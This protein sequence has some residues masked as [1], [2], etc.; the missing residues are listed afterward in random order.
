MDEQ[1][2]IAG[3]KKYTLSTVWTEKDYIKHPTTRLNGK[4]RQ[5]EPDVNIT[6]VYLL[7]LA[8][9]RDKEKKRAEYCA[10]YTKEI[11]LQ[12]QKEYSNKQQSTFIL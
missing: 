12:A 6:K 5:D 10:K 1:V 8:D 9:G 7:Y 11:M 3:A 2:L 4:N